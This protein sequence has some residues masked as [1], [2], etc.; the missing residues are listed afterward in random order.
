MKIL[1]EERIESLKAG[2]VGGLSFCLAYG[3]TLWANALN[4]DLLIPLHMSGEIDEW[5]RWGGAWASGFLFGVT[6][7]YIVRNDRNPHLKGGAVAA[8]AIVRGVA[9]IE[10][11]RSLTEHFGVWVVFGVE[12]LFCCFSAFLALDLALRRGWVQAI[13]GR[14]EE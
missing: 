9:P 10:L 14:D 6:Y 8:F 1:R 5:L 4:L 2:V 13:A 11:E 7:R 12:S 3:L